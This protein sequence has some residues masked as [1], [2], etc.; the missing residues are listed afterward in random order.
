M[1]IAPIKNIKGKLFHSIVF[2]L[3][4]LMTV[5]CGVNEP[6][7]VAHNPWPGYELIGLY[8]SLV[9]ESNENFSIVRTQDSGESV[10]LLKSGQ[11]DAA[12]ITMDEALILKESG[13]KIK[14]VLIFNISAGADVIV[15]NNDISEPNK[16]INKRIAYTP[17]GLSTL[18]L[19]KYF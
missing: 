19:T 14:V 8:Q 17:G 6:L 4:S 3:L 10:A 16:L 1:R 11:V 15:G 18:I 12:A 13:T 9:P 7:K 5:S 2:S